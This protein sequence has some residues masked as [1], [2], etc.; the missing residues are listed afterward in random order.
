MEQWFINE[1]YSQDGLTWKEF[2]LKMTQIAKEHE[3]SMSEDDWY[4][5]R[6]IFDK[7]DKSGD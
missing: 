4:K 6:S 1:L 7:F 5:I 3:Y 2:K